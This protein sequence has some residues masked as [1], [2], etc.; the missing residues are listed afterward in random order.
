MKLNVLNQPGDQAFSFEGKTGTLEAVMTIPEL[1]DPKYIAIIGHPH[2][3]QGGTMNNKVVTTLTRV[4]KCFDIP[5]IRFNFRG[6]GA[7]EGQYDGG[8]GESEDMIL[9][10]EQCQSSFP[11]AKMAFAGFSF[12]SYVAFR[13][14][15]RVQNSLLISI[16]PPIHHYDFNN[17]SPISTHWI[18][19]QGDED[20]VVPVEAV[21]QFVALNPEIN[22]IEFENTG[23]FFH[24][25]LTD[26]KSKLVD[27]IQSKAM[28]CP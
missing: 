13:A 12:G 26:L 4:F 16:A 20:E 1:T 3:L 11:D 10:A 14:A 25:K 5:S 15:A 18:I 19:V 6:V 27:M 23:H 28:I 22:Y 21:R 2:S 7:S 24:G 17:I 9:L 8:I